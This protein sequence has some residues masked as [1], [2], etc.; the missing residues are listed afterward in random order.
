MA[1]WKDILEVAEKID[2]KY[3]D[4]DGDK[5]Y[6]TIAI[7]VQDSDYGLSIGDTVNHLSSVWIDN[8]ETDDFVDGVCA[9]DIEML[10]NYRPRLGS[11]G[12]DGNVI[13]VLASDYSGTLGE[14]D[15][16]VI[17]SDSVVLDV[18]YC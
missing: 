14:D 9:L 12:Y 6:E 11:G 1:D 8:E 13:L 17:L 18:I 3:I 10:K 2:G 7:R 4:D 5:M 15:C 16:E